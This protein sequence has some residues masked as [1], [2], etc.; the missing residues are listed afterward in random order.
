MANANLKK[1]SRFQIGGLPLIHNI[2]T[3][4]NLKGIFDNHLSSHGNE[5]ASTID[6]LTLLV[7]NLTLGKKPLYKL[8]DWSN[9]IDFRCLDMQNISHVNFNDDRFGRALDKLYDIDRA[10]LLTQIVVRVLDEFNI[11]NKRIH[12]DSTSIKAY[13]NIAGATD[14]GLELRYGKSKDHRPDLKQLVFTLSISSDGAVP[15]H[16]KAYP[17]N[18][19]DD[20]THIETWD[21]LCKIT[22]SK[23]F[24]Y[25]ADCKV[26]TDNQLNH[27]ASNT[28]RVITII[29]K[30]WK[31]VKEFKEHLRENTVSK[32]E[33]WRR[34]KPGTLDEQEYFYAYSGEYETHKRGY[35]I[36]W[37]LSSEKKKLD[38][39][40]RDDRLLRAEKSLIE[41]RSKLN[42]RKLKEMST[43]QEAATN[44][45]KK[46]NVERFIII[47]VNKIEETELTQTTKGRP[48][49][50]TQYKEKT[51][52]SYTLGWC[53][54]K[55]L[56]RVE[57]KVD[58][59][60]PL[61][62]TDK[63]LK[64]VEVLQAYKYQPR[65][66]KR[67]TQFKSV[68]KAAPMYFKSIERVE[69]N[70]FVFF[71]ALMVQ[72]LIEREVRAT[73]IKRN[74]DALDIYPE[75]RESKYPTADS[76]L[77]TFESISRYEV[78]RDGRIIEEY[79][80]ELSDVQIQVLDLMKIQPADYWK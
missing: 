75:Q 59:C 6:T 50:N 44:I 7:C 77:A 24:L 72:A 78:V 36:H 57:K 55:D 26:C 11:D 68:H 39:I 9:Q 12:N 20:T 43:I 58:G 65:L 69:S 31:E 74:I 73:M 5:L 16:Y 38:E 19:A 22:G 8:E 71:I 40:S 64:S 10:S 62:C 2:I 33:I 46:N 28:G 25:V 51:N 3:R 52:T 63:S 15:I 14:S 30:I 32:Q 34:T 1:L 29:P 47:D 80:D 53:R 54:N 4:M 48:G 35:K 76:I 60:F 56:L 41:L 61:L 67:F 13:G 42:K 70:L 21:A 23:D 17:G 18:R 79:K 45:L 49:K 66:E 37:I 27:I